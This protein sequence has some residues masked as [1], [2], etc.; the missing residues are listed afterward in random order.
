MAI[1]SDD[2]Q[3]LADQVT[4][5]VHQ[6]ED[7]VYIVFKNKLGD[8]EQSDE[9]EDKS[10]YRSETS[11]KKSLEE[12]V[13]SS[14]PSESI[15]HSTIGRDTGMDQGHVTSKAAISGDHPGEKSETK[16]QEKAAFKR[17]REFQLM[18]QCT[19][20]M[21]VLE[22]LSSFEIHKCTP[23]SDEGEPSS[24][25]P[26]GYCIKREDLGDDF[27]LVVKDEDKNEWIECN[28]CSQR[29][30]SRGNLFTHLKDKHF[31][32]YSLPMT[33][34]LREDVTAE[35]AAE[36]ASNDDTGQ[37]A[38]ETSKGKNTAQT[39]THVPLPTKQFISQK[40]P[41]LASATC[42]LCGYKSSKNGLS[43]HR[44]RYHSKYIFSCVICGR[45][46]GIME[47][48][49]NHYQRHFND[50]GDEQL[51]QALTFMF[52][53]VSDRFKCRVCG[54]E[55]TKKSDLYPHKTFCVNSCLEFVDGWYC[56]KGCSHKSRRNCA[57]IRHY[58]SRHTS[59]PKPLKP[60]WFK[61]DGCQ[62]SWQRRRP[63][64]SHL[65]RCPQLDQD[66]RQGLLRFSS[67]Q[68]KLVGKIMMCQKCEQ[69][70]KKLSSRLNGTV[71]GLVKVAVDPVEESPADGENVTCNICLDVPQDPAEMC[72]YA[73]NN[74]KSPCMCAEC[75]KMYK[76]P[77]YLK[78]HSCSA[79]KPKSTSR[80]EPV[81]EC[82]EV[83]GTSS[84][85]YMILRDE[86]D[87]VWFRCKMC[88]MIGQ[89][90]GW[91]A[92]H[93]DF[94][95]SN[96]PPI[97]FTITRRDGNSKDGSVK[98][99][100]E[101]SIEGPWKRRRPRALLAEK[102]PDLATETCEYCNFRSSK[103]G[104]RSHMIRHHPSFF[105]K[106]KICESGF[107]RL[108]YLREHY[109]TH[110]DE[111]GVRT[112]QNRK[113]HFVKYYRN[114]K[115][116]PPKYQ[117]A[118]CQKQCYR[119]CDLN[120]HKK[121]CRGYDPECRDGFYWC[122][123]CNHKSKDRYKSVIHFARKHQP[124]N[125]ICNICGKGFAVLGDLYIHKKSH[126][127]TKDFKCD[128]CDKT[129]SNH[130]YLRAHKVRHVAVRSFFCPVC[131]KGF[132]ENYDM[133]THM[134][135]HE[136]APKPEGQYKCSQCVRTFT[137]ASALRDHENVHKGV[138]PYKCKVC[139][140]RFQGK[141]ALQRHW[142]KTHV[143][144]KKY[145]CNTCMKHYCSMHSLKHHKC[146]VDSRLLGGD[147]NPADTLN[148]QIVAPENQDNMMMSSLMIHSQATDLGRDIDSTV[149]AFAGTS[150]SVAGDT[151]QPSFFVSTEK[152]LES[153][154]S[155]NVYLCEECSTVMHTWEEVEAHM[156]HL[157]PAPTLGTVEEVIMNEP[158]E[159]I[160]A[161]EMINVVEVA[162]VD[163]DQA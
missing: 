88:P 107:G 111:N 34:S 17:L 31:L 69:N 131:H 50:K 121:F 152:V 159:E 87:Q 51:H 155:P 55:L 122:S 126:T 115:K 114:L 160:R 72:V 37:S 130:R 2:Y 143:E 129:F 57:L 45:G 154:D 74:F 113:S 62:G 44:R 120:N 23:G 5:T 80:Q 132:K 135:I 32:G 4:F 26:V 11:D 60:Q 82:V 94:N 78:T 6:K 29:L 14:S 81:G 161:H 41:K 116:N 95:H 119:L 75:G 15:S 162:F 148:V 85:K 71:D 13:V 128:I 76:S 158:Q 144:Q 16:V 163:D 105:Y 53:K 96:Q 89:Q 77:F 83:D 20:C 118:K 67:L 112:G 139:G 28:T 48:L 54:I 1:H 9:K 141:R 40:N 142:E 63:W 99:P 134:K 102:N 151:D 30:K 86:E 38:D 123:A 24:K 61:C 33:V 98:E 117:C 138:Y 157:H 104:I 136:K 43:F 68:A 70:F 90:K 35:K 150:S 84:E 10:L 133:K 106:C 101:G 66:F 145:S 25:E 100:P 58:I 7:N 79:Y 47:S 108:N 110:F 156:L 46:F 146:R 64:V 124:R 27:S 149:P 21:K 97:P 125:I 137:T 147:S 59:K 49:C 127:L 140:T 153:Q 93:W 18:M 91:L 12:D 3:E 36:E 8:K 103:L 42:E 92:T 65:R 109:K 39:L 22:M 19:R 56:C 73:E 52:H